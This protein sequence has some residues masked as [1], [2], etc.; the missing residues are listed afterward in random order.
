[1]EKPQ[2]IEFRTKKELKQMLEFVMHNVAKSGEYNLYLHKVYDFDEDGRTWNNRTCRS[3][4][5][6]ILKDGLS[7]TKYSSI[8][9]TSVFSGTLSQDSADKILNYN[10]PWPTTEQIVVIIAIPKNININGFETNFSTPQFNFSE[11]DMMR[12][13]HTKSQYTMPYDALKTSFIDVPFIV[14]SIVTNLPTETEEE[15]ERYGK[16][17]LFLNQ[18]HIWKQSEDEKDLIMKPLADKVIAKFDIVETDDKETIDQKI[19]NGIIEMDKVDFNEG[20]YR[21]DYDFD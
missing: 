16:Y 14:G 20:S 1:M 2:P 7:K 17:Q 19:H 21:S 11:Y 18:N 4:M 12:Y 3:N 9:Q 8:H 5:F 13:D 6:G 10:Y 15:F